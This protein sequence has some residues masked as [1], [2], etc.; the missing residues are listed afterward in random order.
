MAAAA[1]AAIPSPM[2]HIDGDAGATP[3]PAATARM[4][5][6]QQVAMHGLNVPWASAGS[7]VLALLFVAMQWP[8][9][10]HPLLLAWLAALLGVMGWRG[11][12]WAWQ[13]RVAEPR[14]SDRSWLRRYRANFLA[15]GLVWAAASAL[16]MSTHD[17]L[18]LALLV[19]MLAGICASNFILNAFDIAAAL[20]FGVPAM[21]ALALRLMANAQGVPPI[22]G[23]AVLLA[24]GF[25]SLTG[26]RAHRMVRENVALRLAEGRQNHLLR[27]LIETTS[28]GFWFIDNQARTVDANPAMCQILGQPRSAL[29]G[30]SIFDFVDDANRAIFE[31]ELQRRAGGSSGGY[32]VA[33]RRPDGSLVDCYNQATPIVDA[34]GR[35][36]G[37][38]G[39][40]TDISDRKRA[41]RQ[42]QETSEALRQKSRALEDTLASIGQGIIHYDGQGLLRTHN[43]RLL[44][45]LDLPASLFG[46]HTTREALRRFQN[47]RGDLASSTELLDKQGDALTLPANLNDMPDL[48]VRRTRAGL[49]VEVR[50]R[51]LADGGMVR[52]FS[53]V[54]AYIEALR[55]LAGREREQRD[56]LDMFPG[57]M[58][59]TDQDYHYSYVNQR[60]A[61]MLGL[62]PSQIVGHHMADVLGAERFAAIRA[63][64]EEVHPGAPVNSES[65]YPA[66]AWRPRLHLQVTHAATV[67][68]T[69]GRRRVYAFAIDISARKAAEAAMQA[70]RD[71]AERANRAKSQ[72]LSSMSHELR[73]PLNA[74]L[75][76]GHL[77]ATDPAHPLAPAQR[78]QLDEILHG[79]QH[80]LQLIN[81]VLDLAVVETGSLPIHLQPVAL[82]PVLTEALALLQPLA[83]S[84]GIQL[85]TRPD[86]LTDGAAVQADPVRLKQVL[87]NLLGNAI[88]YN[89]P[90]GRVELRCQALAPDGGAPG[91]GGWRITVQDTGPGLDEAQQ[92]RLFSAFER[93][94]AEAGRVE[95]TGL[96]LALSR[97][98]VRAM[99]GDIG[100]HSQPGQGSTFWVQ[101][102]PAEARPDTV[103]ALPLPAPPDSH[104]VTDPARLPVVLYIEDN[105]VNLLLMESMFE[106]LPG[107]RLRTASDPAQGLAE[108]TASPPDLLLLDIQLPGMDGFALLQHLRDHPRTRDVPVIAVSADAMPATVH[109]GQAAGFSDYLTKPVEL[110]R[111][112]AA[113]RAALSAR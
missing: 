88:K 101:L 85:P 41:E 79:G 47:E 44:E 87:L 77:L 11:V 67:D 52:T 30:R 113:M 20:L 91:S 46:P 48:Y 19:M 50:T 90:Q 35:R 110:D 71:E 39:L 94:G 63:V 8:A 65:D 98:L 100:V 72:F 37:S 2:L 64:L 69:T 24:L 10:P 23:V 74:I 66:T 4:L 75:G 43:Q 73:T 59:I 109:R 57:F 15:H 60:F 76:F 53:D 112:A 81:E 107:L 56:L 78:Q 83:R 95:G 18:Y 38:V 106:R 55:T 61:D 99:G 62:P 5:R 82:A 45:L 16:P 9:I 28:E 86:G 13:R 7:M 40:W 92:A 29:R 54:T 108:A 68:A 58:I 84:S 93:L 103:A 1:E 12:L 31:R 22:M 26:R 111:L 27:V 105:P 33:L 32:E 102:R 51:Q 3:D 80:L 89:R 42:L 104:G 36:I 6:A 34:E 25:F 70:A 14:P 21:A 97:G 49:L 17:P 96:G